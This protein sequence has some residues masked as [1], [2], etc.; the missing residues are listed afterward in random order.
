[1]IKNPE[2]LIFLKAQREGKGRIG[3]EGFAFSIKEENKTVKQRRE[4]TLKV[5]AEEEALMMGAVAQ[6]ES[7]SSISAENTADEAGPRTSITSPPQ[8]TKR[9]TIK[10]VT[11]ELEAKMDRVKL[12]DHEAMHL[13]GASTCPQQRHQPNGH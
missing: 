10:V 5:K 4:E 12:T 13:F 7:S 9:G 3:V 8:R 2:D 11:P 1:M 6:L